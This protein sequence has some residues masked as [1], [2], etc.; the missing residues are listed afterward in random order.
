MN[1]LWEL[2]PVVA[3]LVL[4]LLFSYR[5]DPRKFRTGLYLLALLVWGALTVAALAVAVVRHRIDDE[6]AAWLLLGL[7][8]FLV[9][10]VVAL[11]VLTANGVTLLRRDGACGCSRWVSGSCHY[12]ALAFTTLSLDSVRLSI[13]DDG[14]GRRWA[15]S[16]ALSPSFSTGRC[17]RR[18]WRAGVGRWWPSSCWARA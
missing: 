3:V 4:A 7:L 13:L 11:A 5:D 16:S 6:A 12:V 15:T 14:P 9:L 2:P 18:S 10:T 17:T 1:P 8:G